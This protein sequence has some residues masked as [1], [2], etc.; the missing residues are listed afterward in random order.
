MDGIMSNAPNTYRL[1][2]IVL[3]DGDD[4]DIIWHLQLE[5]LR[6]VNGPVRDHGFEVAVEQ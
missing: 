3:H 2:E 1:G 4:D 5:R 6:Q